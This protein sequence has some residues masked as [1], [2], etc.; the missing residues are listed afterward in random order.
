MYLWG[1]AG[2][3]SIF[4]TKRTK[5][6]KP[7]EAATRSAS[8]TAGLLLARV[9]VQK[10]HKPAGETAQKARLAPPFRDPKRTEK[11]KRGTIW[12]VTGDYHF[13]DPGSNPRNTQKHENAKTGTTK[14]LFS[15]L[16]S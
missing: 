4:F 15:G 5:R 8:E 9:T 13:H 11:R 2:I 10:S 3:G 14:G 7:R 1:E 16:V 12:W 6:H